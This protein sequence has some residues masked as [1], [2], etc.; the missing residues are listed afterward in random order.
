MTFWVSFQS[1]RG[2]HSC[3]I[4]VTYWIIRSA[5][6]INWMKVVPRNLTSTRKRTCPS[7]LTDVIPKY[8]KAIN[9]DRMNGLTPGSYESPLPITKCLRESPFVIVSPVMTRI[10][11]SL[12]LKITLRSSLLHHSLNFFLTITL[13]L[14][15]S[16]TIFLTPAPSPLT[17]YVCL[18]FE[19]IFLSRKIRSL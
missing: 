10:A 5:S 4:I 6:L 16:H 14:S 12:Y 9:Y 2:L 7:A 1:W 11:L 15:L 3:Q 17:L 8:H 13:S 18:S 19:P